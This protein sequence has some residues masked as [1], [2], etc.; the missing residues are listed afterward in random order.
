MAASNRLPRVNARWWGISAMALCACL[1][2]AA[3]LPAAERGPHPGRGGDKP[4]P[5]LIAW[6]CDGKDFTP[7]DLLLERIDPNINYAWGGDNPAPEVPGENF[8]ARWH[9]LL[10]V[11][12][13]GHYTIATVTDDGVRLRLDGKQIIDQWVDQGDTRVAAEVD[14]TEG[15]HPIEMDYYQGGGGSTAKLLWALKGGFD[16]RIIPGTALW[17]LPEDMLHPVLKAHTAELTHPDFP[18]G[19][20]PADWTE[21]KSADAQ[22][23]AHMTLGWEK[24]LRREDHDTLGLRFAVKTAVSR[25]HTLQR[26]TTPDGSDDK[27]L[28]TTVGLQQ[29]DQTATTFRLAYCWDP[30]N[31]VA[32]GMWGRYSTGVWVVHQGRRQFD[33][34]PYTGILDSYFRPVYYRL[35]LLSDSILVQA[36]NQRYFNYRTVTVIH[37]RKNGMSGSPTTVMGF[38]TIPWDKDYGQA[39]LQND[40]PNNDMSVEETD[41]LYVD[42]RNGMDLHPAHPPEVGEV[43]DW[44]D[45]TAKLMQHDQPTQWTM[46]ILGHDYRT[47]FLQP[48]VIEESPLLTAEA[49]KKAEVAF[50]S[51]DLKERSEP[52]T[53]AL[54]SI[55]KTKEARHTAA[56]LETTIPHGDDPFVRILCGVSEVAAAS[57]GGQ[58]IS[59]GLRPGYWDV[60]PDRYAMI[61][62]ADAKNS[63]VLRFKLWANDRDL[64]LW[65]KVQPNFPDSRIAELQAL[66]K[67]FPKEEDRIRRI[68]ADLEIGALG[69]QFYDYASA[70]AGFEAALNEA[71]AA[72]PGP[73]R[74]QDLIDHCLLLLLNEAEL[75]GDTERMTQWIAKI[76]TLS[77]APELLRRALSCEAEVHVW[78][79]GPAAAAGWLD[80]TAEG[81]KDPGRQCEL[82]R[83]AARGYQAWQMTDQAAAELDAA[84]KACPDGHAVEL[85]MTAAQTR[86]DAAMAAGTP[87][88]KAVTPLLAQLRAILQTQVA[89]SKQ[90]PPQS[91]WSAYWADKAT[92][93]TAK[94][95]PR[96]WSALQAAI[97][98]QLLWT[99]AEPAQRAALFAGQPMDFSKAADIAAGKFNFD[100]DRLWQLSEP[101]MTIGAWEVHPA[102]PLVLD[103]LAHVFPAQNGDGP[104]LPRKLDWTQT[105]CIDR[106]EPIG[107]YH[108]R[109]TLMIPDHPPADLKVWFALSGPGRIWIDGKLVYEQTQDVKA[110]YDRA[111]L[112]A[113]MFTTGAHKVM[114]KMIHADR[115]QQVRLSVRLSTMSAFRVYLEHYEAQ[116]VLSNWWI[117]TGIADRLSQVNNLYP[118]L[119]SDLV[120]MTMWLQPQLGTG[121]Q[122]DS[123]DGILGASDPALQNG[124]PDWS[125][126]MLSDAA[127]RLEDMPHFNHHADSVY[128]LL[129]RW[130][131]LGMNQFDLAL[132][133]HAH[134]FGEAEGVSGRPG[135]FAAALEAQIQALLGNRQT[136]EE[137]IQRLQGEYADFDVAL[138]NAAGLRS[139][140][141]RRER[142]GRDFQTSD[143]AAADIEDA[144]RMI[145]QEDYR[146]A[147]ERLLKTAAQH[148]TQLYR[149]A[150]GRQSPDG[151]LVA[152]RTHV[153]QILRTMPAAVWPIYTAEYDGRSADALAA[154]DKTGDLDRY[155]AVADDFPFTPGAFAALNRAAQLEIDAGRPDHA[156]VW[157]QRLFQER[158]T[159]DNAG[160]K[161]PADAPTPPQI[162]FKLAW[163]LMQ[164]GR[165]EEAHALLAP[166]DPAKAFPADAQLPYMGTPTPLTK[167]V[168]ELAAQPP[169]PATGNAAEAAWRSLRGDPEQTGRVDAD[170]PDQPPT[171]AW[172]GQTVWNADTDL[173]KANLIPAP[174]FDG[175]ALP[176]VAGSSVV[177]AGDAGCIVRRLSDGAR[178]WSDSWN[179]DLLNF[180][181][182]GHPIDFTGVPVHAPDV[183]DGVVAARAIVAGHG[184]FEARSLTDGRLIASTRFADGLRHYHAFGSPLLAD[185]KMIGR[186]LSMSDSGSLAVAA[187]DLKS[188][189]LAWIQQLVSGSTA[190]AFNDQTLTLAIQL[191]PPALHD[192]VLYLDTGEGAIAAID[193]RTG[194]PLW[195]THFDRTKSVAFDDNGRERAERYMMTPFI[196]AP[197]IANGLV[198]VRPRDRAVLYAIDAA[199]GQ[200]RWQTRSDRGWYLIGAAQGRLYTYDGALQCLDT[201]TGRPIWKTVLDPADLLGRGFLARNGLV[202]PTVNGLTLYGFDDGRVLRTLA[203]GTPP[204]AGHLTPVVAHGQLTG[205]LQTDRGELRWWRFGG[206]TAPAASLETQIVTACR[207]QTVA[208]EDDENPPQ[209]AVA[210]ATPAPAVTPPAWWPALQAAVKDAGQDP[211]GF[212]HA[213]LNDGLI[214]IGSRW[215]A[216]PAVLAQPLTPPPADPQ[217]GYSIPDFQAPL[218]PNTPTASLTP[219]LRLAGG[220]AKVLRDPNQP[221][222]VYVYAGGVVTAVDLSDSLPRVLWRQVTTGDLTAFAA[223]AG[224]V[225][226]ASYNTFE[227]FDAANG[228]PLL[229]RRLGVANSWDRHSAWITGLA[230]GADKVAA[231]LA[232]EGGLD[233]L[234]D[235]STHNR[236]VAV[237]DLADGRRRGVRR[238]GGSHNI[239]VGPSIHGNRMYAFETPEYYSQTGWFWTFDLSTGDALDHTQLPPGRDVTIL[240]DPDNR[241]YFISHLDDLIWFDAA[242]GRPAWTVKAPLLDA[243]STHPFGATDSTVVL[244]GSHGNGRPYE[245]D[246]LDRKTGKQLATWQ[247]A[248]G[249]LP[250][251]A[252]EYYTFEGVPGTQD[253]KIIRHD[254]SDPA[255]PVFEQIWPGLAPNFHLTPYAYVTGDAVVMFTCPRQWGQPGWYEALVFSR[256][257]G[258]LIHR[259]VFSLATPNDPWNQPGAEVLRF[260]QK[261]LLVGEDGALVIGPLTH[262]PKNEPVEATD[263]KPLVA[264]LATSDPQLANRYRTALTTEV[265]PISMALRFGSKPPVVDGVLSEWEGFDPWEL[266]APQDYV[267]FTR[268]PLTNPA[269]HGATIR[270]AWDHTGL[271]LAIEVHDPSR[272]DAPTNADY[273]L[274][275]S[276]RVTVVGDSQRTGFV[277]SNVEWLDLVATGMGSNAQLTR[278]HGDEDRAVQFGLAPRPDLG[279]GGRSLELYIPWSVLN[280]NLNESRP[281]KMIRLLLN[282]AIPDADQGCAAQGMFEFG[283]GLT[284]NPTDPVE[285]QRFGEIHLIDLSSERMAQML[286]VIDLIPDDPKAWEIMSLLQETMRGAVGLKRRIAMYEGFVRKHPDSPVALRA[287]AQLGYLYGLRGEADPSATVLAFA[288]DCKVPDTSLAAYLKCGFHFKLWLNPANP[289]S[290]VMIQFETRELG[291]KR[292]GSWGSLL[293]DWGPRDTVENM[294]LGPLPP[295]GKWLDMFIPSAT[296][297]LEGQTVDGVAFTVCGGDARFDAAQ[298]ID[299]TGNSLVY[300]DDS[301]EGFTFASTHIAWDTQ[302]KASGVRSF[303]GATH[304]FISNLSVEPTN[305]DQRNFTFPFVSQATTNPTPD[306][307]EAWYQA[308]HLLGDHPMGWEFFQRIVTYLTDKQKGAGLREAYARYVTE[309]PDSPFAAKALRAYHE[310]GQNR[311]AVDEDYTKVEALMKSAK[312]TTDVRRAFYSASYPGLTAL[313]ICGPLE[314]G[315][316]AGA[317]IEFDPEKNLDFKAHLQGRLLKEQDPAN[318]DAELKHRDVTWTA[319]DLKEW[320]QYRNQADDFNFRAIWPDPNPQLYNRVG[321]AHFVVT[322]PERRTAYLYVGANRILTVYVNGKLVEKNINSRWVKDHTVLAIHL[323]TGDNQVLLK[324]GNNEQDLDL[325]VRVADR[326]GRPI[327]DLKFSTTLTP[328]KPEPKK[329][330]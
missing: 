275:D 112:P 325:E 217:V 251:G 197:C 101:Q 242:A 53:F 201:A 37:G 13:A 188:G 292:R 147:L 85:A 24:T 168:A 208:P 58:T 323:N 103:S 254:L 315:P 141:G 43:T 206:E 284:P 153:Y 49:A 296:I 86:L 116:A 133:E 99:S 81:V 161:T 321:F 40:W 300:I 8:Y 136:V 129:D 6:F 109:A 67:A 98:E 219:L 209:A 150:G 309:N 203:L 115:N 268:Q 117:P 2:A 274:G 303:Y 328:E 124:A 84:A 262:G 210:A 148:G 144:Q 221:S 169:A 244:M 16:E 308:A 228:L 30:L 170:L 36:S 78:Q 240:G 68:Q 306:Q 236:V 162:R 283:A 122:A 311:F 183:A 55:F 204:S 39:N 94:S 312:V 180:T 5:G 137:T 32:V 193:V 44:D 34:G 259:D 191:P 273:R 130:Y 256:Q 177:C 110:E 138:Q 166:P 41:I 327:P 276:I 157:L 51:V 149:V 9:G 194:T 45:T 28:I 54:G 285:P 62:R 264:S 76:R 261:F 281:D 91:P 22:G 42:Q 181:D 63:G 164:V 114:A 139:R 25:Y 47:S 127:W 135:A 301:D 265:P 198:L 106:N 10:R 151:R 155:L 213:D 60:E 131:S 178:L 158:T 245:V 31:F 225:A 90:T 196:G 235:W 270:S 293:V 239:F 238:L 271:Y 207:P 3:A 66:I 211:H 118:Y 83:L 175:P 65:A 38:G 329:K 167:L 23:Q 179:D 304:E 107:V 187:I 159:R 140:E 184:A 64:T 35:V 146:Q 145:E 215:A 143:D 229:A 310:M 190:L 287:V 171:L 20:N 199:S 152:V 202:L 12:K 189:R 1:A 105:V 163:V 119:P 255:K 104:W 120:A 4:K 126:R 289:P 220:K 46:A 307:I 241:G 74:R 97:F 192:G 227:V 48:Q 195:I 121:A 173:V 59:D 200:I 125:A 185:G 314:G 11:K 216:A 113:S 95:P 79:A 71:L 14:L 111:W 226:V 298:F 282:V 142:S 123:L 73:D 165:T 286:K 56:L 102:A 88:E 294:L 212:V 33:V 243:D 82:H 288:A 267:A 248:G 52:Y 277:L 154:A 250:E 258:I 279:A 330:H 231:F 134:R 249:V 266:T 319:I 233:R 27:P 326:T 260:G 299:G 280:V 182:Q 218:P 160:M 232:D 75:R 128:A 247:N 89:A 257:S 222:R 305:R 318:P 324:V 26:K 50:A 253:L 186:F 93:L 269:L 263:M 17:H 316:G 317:D 61:G 19:Y 252:S 21:Q 290:Q 132:L 80:Q 302:N 214:H 246:V 172:V 234:G 70:R 278:L 100:R 313:D 174:F 223:N 237:Y 96:A 205:V 57:V 272:Q 295:T 156:V 72:P 92:E 176:A 297:G 18:D 29:T 77:A 291:W 87:A 224:R 69:M 7:K 108:A 230:V 15:D 322:S 320:P